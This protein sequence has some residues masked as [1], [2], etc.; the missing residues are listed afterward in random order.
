MF[1]WYKYYK[2]YRQRNQAYCKFQKTHFKTVLYSFLL[3][4][5]DKNNLILLFRDNRTHSF[6]MMKV[7]NTL[8]IG[9]IL[10][11]LQTRMYVS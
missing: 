7:I 10:R 3:I 11:I 5:L 4:F 2:T 8:H 1:F 9:Q 6:E